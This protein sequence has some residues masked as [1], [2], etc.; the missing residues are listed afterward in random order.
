MLILAA[1]EVKWNIRMTVEQ[2]LFPLNHLTTSHT[3]GIAKC[4][5]SSDARIESSDAWEY[6]L[7]S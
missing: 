3:L 2:L 4:V 5:D 7:P 1:I 6:S